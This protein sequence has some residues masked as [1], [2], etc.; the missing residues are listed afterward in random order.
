MLFNQVA[1]VSQTYYWPIYFQ[2]VKATSARASGLYLLPLIVSCTLCTLTAGWLISRIGFYVPFMWLGA[3]VLATGS[4][5]YLLIGVH[6][7]ARQWVLYQVV[8]GIGYGICTQIPLL[9]VQVVLDPALV[10]TGCVMVLFFQ[11]LGGALA[12]SISQNLF[13]DALLKKLR[14][15]EDVDGA[16]VVRAGA[17]DFRSIVGKEVLGRVI[18][19][20]NGALKHV[21]VLAC[22]S[23]GVALVMSLGMEWRTMPRKEKKEREGNGGENA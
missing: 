10:P 7:P 9:S 13:T 2:S 20:F 22:V 5:L 12:T 21:F 1:M 14:E 6:S 15:I 23:A 11:C 19:A 4:G 3:P 17:K 18:E 8:S 16:A